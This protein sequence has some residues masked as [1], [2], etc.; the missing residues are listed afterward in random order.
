METTKRYY[1]CFSTGIAHVFALT[2]FTYSDIK[3]LANTMEPTNG[4]RNFSSLSGI[5]LGRREKLFYV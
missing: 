4:G 1:L 5:L 2:S 3:F